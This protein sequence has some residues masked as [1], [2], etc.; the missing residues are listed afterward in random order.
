MGV[1]MVKAKENN[2]RKIQND[3]RNKVVKYKVAR[4]YNLFA[5]KEFSQGCQEEKRGYKKSQ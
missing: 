2:K 4:D 1:N 3:E 5:I